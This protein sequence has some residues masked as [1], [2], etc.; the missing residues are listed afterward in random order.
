[1]EYEGSNQTADWIFR[2]LVH[3]ARCKI[4]SEMEYI[5]MNRFIF[6]KVISF[7]TLNPVSAIFDHNAIARRDEFVFTLDHFSGTSWSAC[8]I[9]AF[10]L[11]KISE[12][13]D[14]IIDSLVL[15]FLESPG[16]SLMFPPFR[17]G[18]LKLV[19]YVVD[20]SLLKNSGPQI[21]SDSH[22][23]LYIVLEDCNGSKIKLST[24]NFAQIQ[25]WKAYIEK[26]F[27]Q[28]KKSSL[29]ENDS[30]HIPQLVNW[31]QADQ[32]L[33]NCSIS[34]YH[35]GSKQ[36]EIL[37]N[38]FSGL[39]IINDSAGNSPACFQKDTYSKYSTSLDLPRLLSVENISSQL[40]I[41]GS[42]SFV[43]SPEVK[44]FMIDSPKSLYSLRKVESQN[45][46]ETPK[47]D[48][49]FNS[50]FTGN[51][52][53]NGRCDEN[54]YSDSSDGSYFT[55]SDCECCENNILSNESN[56]T[57][58][59]FE[60]VSSPSQI[61]VISSLSVVPTNTNTNTSS[62]HDAI[63]CLP[64]LSRLYNNGSEL[65]K[66]ES[67]DSVAPNVEVS[68]QNIQEMESHLEPLKS[69]NS[70][71][72]PI[73]S[74]KSSF[75]SHSDLETI[76]SRSENT[77]NNDHSKL[78]LANSLNPDNLLTHKS[79]KISVESQISKNNGQKEVQ[80]F[81]LK[82][83]T[84]PND[85]LGVNNQPSL[86]KRKKSTKGL[87]NALKQFF[88]TKKAEQV[89]P[90][91]QLH[92]EIKLRSKEDSPS[93]IQ[94]PSKQ[95]KITHSQKN[96]VLQD[97]QTTFPIHHR[98]SSGGPSYIR[99][100][101]CLSKISEE[102]AFYE[103]DNEDGGIQTVQ[104]TTPVIEE[105]SES[106][107]EPSCNKPFIDV[108]ECSDLTASQYSLTGSKESKLNGD[109]E[110]GSKNF[111]DT[112]RIINVFPVEADKHISHSISDISV[113]TVVDTNNSTVAESR[114]IRAV[115]SFPSRTISRLSSSSS[116]GSNNSLSLAPSCSAQFQN[117]IK[118]RSLSGVTLFDK[119]GPSLP[120][121]K[122]SKDNHSFQN[123]FQPDKV[124]ILKTQGIISKW[125]DYKWSKISNGTMSI[126]VS[127]CG[128]GVGG[129]VEC[130]SAQD[131]IYFTLGIVD[132]TQIRRGT[133]VDVEIG[134]ADLF[135]LETDPI[136]IPLV[137]IAD[138]MFMIRFF[139][140]LE[141][142]EFA[143]STDASRKGLI[144]HDS[145]KHLVDSIK[146]SNSSILPNEIFD[147]DTLDNRSLDC[148]AKSLNHRISTG[149]LKSNSTNS[150]IP[151]KIPIY[152]ESLFSQ[153][154]NF[155]RGCNPT[156]LP[157][158][159]SA[160][161]IGTSLD[162]QK[163]E[164]HSFISY[165]NGD[166]ECSELLLINDLS[167]KLLKYVSKTDVSVMGSTEYQNTSDFWVDAGF[168][169]LRVYSVPFNHELRRVVL[170]DN[171]N[172]VIFENRLSYEAF[173]KVGKLS[174]SISVPMENDR[175]KEYHPILA[176]GMSSAKTL[177]QICEVLTIS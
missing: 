18:H 127:V 155:S 51:N 39:N 129:I 9:E 43:G 6:N 172:H 2:G 15:C 96:Q 115:A 67:V 54:Y 128:F 73:L 45:T 36:E 139:S 90:H 24:S 46:E 105:I 107:D 13:D 42:T 34:G 102:D 131:D 123:S 1:M 147:S 81:Q 118:N 76:H 145:E 58:A 138:P 12:L 48:G 32:S 141:A 160:K 162:S 109:T 52:E 55:E 78:P 94:Y 126:C 82:E 22:M 14:D 125:E 136:N 85:N 91:P 104:H 143:H 21:L 79:Q 153:G 41:K 35:F 11:K 74:P 59:K 171:G 71:T 23:K 8:N 140:T 68:L 88:K 62:S 111:D 98:Q 44:A 124:I 117:V 49:D 133:A 70:S 110:L 106:I 166:V 30:I 75:C 50:I 108:P 47:I 87:F 120:F 53:E 151:N 134:G 167:C 89:N 165:D 77:L 159:L 63:K 158:L 173:E 5:D 61:P 132:R 122:I 150:V 25:Q 130:A 7:E 119:N 4:E 144:C 152:N 66:T 60:W 163:G 154:P 31:K 57:L 17:A 146:S 121:H 69:Q 20:N 135:P 149:S 84:F 157:P 83:K 142:E 28:D 99:N 174:L 113:G 86:L 148:Q 176:L 92:N 103:C 56:S 37:N 16:R 3:T 64:N 161:N 27:D 65:Q 80:N 164:A 137:A 19:D 97:F 101:K 40:K 72:I 38:P 156:F 114:T 112:S 26:L 10:L 95:E 169:R 177:N 33:F 116:I 29:A 168:V 175:S 93:D 170:L 100:D